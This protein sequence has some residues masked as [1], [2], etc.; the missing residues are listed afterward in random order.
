[1]NQDYYFMNIALE[2]AQKGMG[3]VS[4]NPMVGAVVV[5][6]G[7]IVGKGYH[8]KSGA[9]HAEIIALKQAGLQAR[10]ST[11]YVTLEPCNHFGKTPPCTLAI[12]KSGVKRVVFSMN[13]PNRFVSGSGERELNNNGIKTLSGV[14]ENEA[15]RLN[16][17]YLKF[18]TTGVPFVTLKLAVTLD[19]KVSDTE[20]NSRWITNHDTRTFVH[21]LRSSS[22]AVMVGSGTVKADNPLLNSRNVNGRNPLKVIVDSYLSVP[23]D[24]RVFS[25]GNVIVAVTDKADQKKAEEL[26]SRGIEVLYFN[27]YDKRVP[28]GELIVKLAERNVSSV[29]CEGGPRLAASLVNEKLV[30][31]F[32]FTVA[33]KILGKGLS[34]FDGLNIN[35]IGDAL[36]LKNI[37]N[38]YFGGD[39]VITGYP[40]IV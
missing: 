39:T 8:Q 38:K 21:A 3:T 19:G 31:K 22:D 9:D 20:G 27:S 13:D 33:P 1:M 32:I 7:L 16:E 37:E 14:L 30:D 23:T 29:L 10:S 26:T 35:N 12:I 5:K 11:M 17:V 2:L 36:C 18:I 34:A 24:S 40:E 4:P 15:R 28:L 6:N 25:D